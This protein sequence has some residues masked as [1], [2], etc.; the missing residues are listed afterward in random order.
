MHG[1]LGFLRSR[2]RSEP[3]LSY[4]VKLTNE[5]DPCVC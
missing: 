3:Y 2:S 5:L 1:I 4:L